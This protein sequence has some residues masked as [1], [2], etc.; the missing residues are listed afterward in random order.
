MGLGGRSEGNQGE[1]DSFV[2]GGNLEQNQT[3]TGHLLADVQPDKIM[4]GINDEGIR[5]QSLNITQNA[6]VS[7]DKMLHFIITAGFTII[8]K[9][10]MHVQSPISQTK[11][12]SE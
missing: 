2:T 11:Y 6:S 1:E 12:I 7:P 4:Q 9:T 8:S 10:C 5:T 3:Y